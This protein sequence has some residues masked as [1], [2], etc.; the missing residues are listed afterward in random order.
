MKDA[1]QK[2]LTAARAELEALNAQALRDGSWFRALLE[3]FA[4]RFHDKQLSRSEAEAWRARRPDLSE[5]RLS[6]QIIK[7]SARRTGLVGGVAGASITASELLAL[8]SFGL[9]IGGAFLVAMAE[10]AVL[11]RVQLGMIFTLADQH[12]YEMKRRHAYEVGN[13]YGEMF[14]VKG[15]TRLAKFMRGASV[16][17]FKRIGTRFVQRAAVK[18]CMPV[19]SIGIGGGMNYLLTRSLGGHSLRRF[20]KGQGA[21]PIESLVAQS[22]AQQRMLLSLLTL[23]AQADGEIDQREQDLLRKALDEMSADEAER[24]ALLGAIESAEETLF[25]SM[26]A[27]GDDDFHELVME[28]MALMAVADGRLT[29]GELALLKRASGVT[30]LPL[31]EKA[32]RARCA[33]F[34]V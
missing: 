18:Y 9:P 22:E 12:R 26:K 1:I 5:A 2:Q 7:T 6:K 28:L 24:A 13:I 19:L 17:L 11:E 25:E 34:L 32:L 4:Q 21:T 33:E 23:M 14:K 3:R 31:E 10:M 30:G 29:D 8:G 27:V 20:E 15:A 16:S